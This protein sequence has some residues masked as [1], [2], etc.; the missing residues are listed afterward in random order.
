MR[1][2]SRRGAVAISLGFSLHACNE[3]PAVVAA[4]G[5]VVELANER[6]TV[7]FDDDE[8]FHDFAELLV[9]ED[10][11]LLLDDTDATVH[12]RDLH[13]GDSLWT[14]GRR[15]GGPGEFQA[16]V[17]L[18]DAGPGR[19]GVADSQQGRLTV[20]NGPELDQDAATWPL[21]GQLNSS[22]REA[23]GSIVAIRPGLMKIVR[24][25]RETLPEVV[26]SIV[27][28]VPVYNEVPG[29]RQARF[30][31]SRQGRCIVWQPK[32]DYFF[33]FSTSRTS[34]PVFRRYADPYPTPQIDRSGPSPRAVSAPGAAKDA[35]VF[36]DSLFVLRGS[37][38]AGPGARV[39]VYD[40]GTGQRIKSL[41][42]PHDDAFQID[43]AKGVLVVHRST[44]RGSIVTVFDR[45]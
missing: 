38:Y 39:D 3:R 6:W 43:V 29:L 28:P 7:R 15:G 17:E 4:P 5:G 25:R 30:A 26:D 45:S 20:F 42:I 24:L 31:R 22:C 44:E 27:W 33:E 18:V 41:A 12:A 21:D 34:G 36:G 1:L 32:G 40:L 23:T 11:V 13:T 8:R 10:R 37:M 19:F 16:P 14:T 35:A 9:Q 2:F